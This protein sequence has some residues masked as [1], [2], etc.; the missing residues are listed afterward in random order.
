MFNIIYAELTYYLSR[1]F[2]FIELK[3]EINSDF[4]IIRKLPVQNNSIYYNELNLKV[5]YNK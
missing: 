1:E 4:K 3:S 5:I 2:I